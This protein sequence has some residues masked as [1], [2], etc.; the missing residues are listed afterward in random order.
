MLPILKNKPAYSGI[1]KKGLKQPF[2]FV[3]IHF[4]KYRIEERVLLISNSMKID[5]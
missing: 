4:G 3:L 2:F 1:I 5:F